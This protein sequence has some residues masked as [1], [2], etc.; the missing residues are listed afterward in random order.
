MMPEIDGWSVLAQLRQHPLTS[1]VPI[2]I[3]TILPQEELS[4]SLGANA[5]IRKPIARR[6]FLDTLDEQ[7]KLTGSK[8][9]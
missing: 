6:I 9:R 7:I 3:C 2:I 4:L 8:P 1:H 5:F